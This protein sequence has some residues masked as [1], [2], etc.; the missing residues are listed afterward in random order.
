V[1]AQA[2]LPWYNFAQPSLH[3]I[4]GLGLEQMNVGRILEF[5]ISMIVSL[6]HNA[7]LAVGIELSVKFVSKSAKG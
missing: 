6:M 1:W 7:Q 3:I 2:Q 4:N 5:T